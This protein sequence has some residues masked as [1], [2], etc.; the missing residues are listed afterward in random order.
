MTPAE[1]EAADHC[2]GLCEAERVQA[3]LPIAP[4]PPSRMIGSVVPGQGPARRSGGFGSSGP[5]LPP[6]QAEG[7]GSASRRKAAAPVRGVAPAAL[8]RGGEGPDTAPDL[9]A[10]LE[11]VAA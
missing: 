3:A 10:H 2:R 5:V 8:R 9:G 6:W 1:A 4:A 11:E 7:P